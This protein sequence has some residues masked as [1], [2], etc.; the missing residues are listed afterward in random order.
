MWPK[1]EGTTLSVGYFG[2]LEGGGRVYGRVG[3]YRGSGRA[4][5]MGVGD[6]GLGYGHVGWRW[7]SG[8]GMFGLEEVVGGVLEGGIGF[9]FLFQ[10][11]GEVESH[12][13]GGKEDGESEEKGKE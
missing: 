6:G 5:A 7:S 2:G 10:E 8:E 12:G 11:N 9:I 3:W 13:N 1:E 4:V